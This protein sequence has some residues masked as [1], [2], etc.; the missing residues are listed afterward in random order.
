MS[1][2][3]WPTYPY[4]FPGST[5]GSEYLQLL[6]NYGNEYIQCDE[7]GGSCPGGVDDYWTEFRSYYG[8]YNCTMGNWAH[9]EVNGSGQQLC[10]LTGGGRIC[11]RDG[12]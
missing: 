6:N 7:Y 4:S 10:N 5:Y 1:S 9:I 3:K 12:K 11:Y 2:Y 8:S